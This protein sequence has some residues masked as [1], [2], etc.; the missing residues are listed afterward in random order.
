MFEKNCINKMATVKNL[1]KKIP[2]GKKFVKFSRDTLDDRKKLK[3]WINSHQYDFSKDNYKLP[4]S[5]YSLHS[6]G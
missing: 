3:I 2:N 6:T 4:Y 5:F 1:N